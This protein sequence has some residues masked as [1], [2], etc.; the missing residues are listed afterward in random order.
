MVL[1]KNLQVTDMGGTVV[2]YPVEDSFNAGVF[3]ENFTK[4]NA[5]IHSVKLRN[6]YNVAILDK[7]KLTGVAVYVRKI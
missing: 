4:S 3:L 5:V 6:S 7:R 1:G 2:T